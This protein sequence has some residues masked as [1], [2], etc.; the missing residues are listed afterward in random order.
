MHR[1][2]PIDFSGVEGKIDFKPIS[3]HFEK[4]FF[5]SSYEFKTKLD[6]FSNKTTFSITIKLAQIK[7]IQIFNTFE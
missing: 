6:S 1:V 7:Y 4:Q 2:I 5:S 3:L